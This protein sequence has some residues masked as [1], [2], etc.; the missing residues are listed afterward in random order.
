MAQYCNQGTPAFSTNGLS[1]ICKSRTGG[2]ALKVSESNQDDKWSVVHSVNLHQC[3][4]Q[5]FLECLQQRPP[6]F[7]LH[8]PTVQKWPQHLISNQNWL[9]HK[10][11]WSSLPQMTQT[12]Q[13]TSIERSM[14]ATWPCLQLCISR[15][16]VW[17]NYD[18]CLSAPR[19]PIIS[20]ITYRDKPWSIKEEGGGH[21]K[22]HRVYLM[23]G[24]SSLLSTIP[25]YDVHLH[26]CH[27][28]LHLS[29]G[30]SVSNQ[31][32]DDF[33]TEHFKATSLLRI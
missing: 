15:N 5:S 14:T 25:T 4:Y 1:G 9:N 18:P 28:P 10:L 8:I 23:N 12:A 11:T 6:N 17:R 31:H 19:A 22:R 3:H 27:I 30:H 24:P 21:L 7:A 32:G 2:A 16:Q 26:S 13:P 29:S 33:L 20:P